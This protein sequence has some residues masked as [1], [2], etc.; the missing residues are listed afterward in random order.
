MQNDDNKR[1]VILVTGSS[2]RIGSGIICAAHQQGYNVIVHYHHSVAAATQLVETLNGKRAN[3]AKMVQGNLAIINDATQLQQF[4][5]EVMACFGQLDA[6]VHNASRFYPTPVNQTIATLHKSW[7]ELFL[8][9]AKAP[10]FLTQAFLPQLQHSKGS[11]VS[12]L[13]IHANG[14]PFKN[15]SLY[16]MAKAAQQMMVQT[17]ALELAP[18][19]RVNGVAPGVNVFPD[20]HSDQAIGVQQQQQIVDSI[21]LNCVGTP[22]DIANAVLFLLQAPYVTGQIIAVDGGRSLTLAGG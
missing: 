17:L 7:N 8:T 6:L 5:N 9:N 19:V 22:E 4:V 3:S 20:M 13:D 16:N 18:Q 15:Y 21:P 14:K 11:V 10:F 2:K 12:L 1:L